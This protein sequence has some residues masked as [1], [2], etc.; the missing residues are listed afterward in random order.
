MKILITRL[1][2]VDVERNASK[3]GNIGTRRIIEN[4]FFQ[5]NDAADVARLFTLRRRA[6]DERRSVDDLENGGGRT[7][8]H[9]NGFDVGRR[10]PDLHATGQD[11]KED[12][13][14][15]RRV[16]RSGAVARIQDQFDAVPEGQRETA[17]QNR[18]EK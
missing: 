3:N 16:V 11:A 4:D 12:D 18:P 9:R 2:T 8:S 13:Q 5:G 1:A 6:V 7:T 17:V 14:H 15:R 10:G